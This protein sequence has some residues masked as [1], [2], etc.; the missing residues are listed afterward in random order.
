LVHSGVEVLDL[1]FFEEETDLVAGLEEVFVP[2][3]IALLAGREFGH[4]MIF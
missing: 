2:D 1:T 4:W 3:V